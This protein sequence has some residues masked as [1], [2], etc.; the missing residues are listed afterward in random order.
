MPMV[1]AWGGEQHLWR[2]V[3]GGLYSK[4]AA[5][6]PPCSTGSD[7]VLTTVDANQLGSKLP[8]P[9]PNPPDVYLPPQLAASQPLTAAAQQPAS[10]AGLPYHPL[11]L[12]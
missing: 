9:V 11:P 6:A 12:F 2:G 7:A 1:T 3:Q 10:A 5:D 8:C 4:P